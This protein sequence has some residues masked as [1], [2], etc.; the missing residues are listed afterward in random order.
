[1]LSAPAEE[2]ISDSGKVRSQPWSSAANEANV[3][4]FEKIC[5]IGDAVHSLMPLS[6][7]GGSQAIEGGAAVAL[8]LSLAG[9]RP[10]DVPLA[11]KVSSLPCRSLR[12]G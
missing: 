8:A 3:R 11:L 12:N 2:W 5:F 4:I 10:C 9:G 6:F 7:Q 1:M